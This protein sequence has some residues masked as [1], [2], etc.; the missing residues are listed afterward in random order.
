MDAA[1]EGVEALGYVAEAAVIG[2]AFAS[3]FS[4]DDNI[5]WFC[6]A[7]LNDVVRDDGAMRITIDRN[8]E[9]MELEASLLVAADGGQSR[10]RDKFK[11]KTLRLGYGQ[12]AVIANV[13]T[14]RPHNGIAYERFTDSGP[15]ALL[16]NNAPGWM[17]GHE[18]GD[19]R[20]SVV[21]TVHDHELAEHLALSDEAFIERLQRRFGKRAGRF[22][23]VTPRS[24]YPLGL[25]FVREA[26]APGLV[27]IGNAAHQIHPVGGQGFNLGL[28]DVAVL[29]EVIGDCVAAGGDIAALE[30]LQRYAGWRRPDYLRV[31]TFTDSLV[32]LF[33]SDFTPLAAGRNLGLVAMDLVLPLRRMLTRQAMG[34]SGRQSRLALGLSLMDKGGS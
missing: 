28:R 9:S 34:V 13:T 7:T 20:W 12:V 33:S 26:V 5:D 1:E 8:G 16:P 17:A 14:D 22:T 4:D 23:S 29:A 6:P 31:A 15:L 3:G 25:Q 24:H 19:R 10:V 21:W 27:Y 2:K 30:S 32:R 18:A 11:P